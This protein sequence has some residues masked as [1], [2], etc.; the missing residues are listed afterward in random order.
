MMER[1]FGWIWV[2]LGLMGLMGVVGYGAYWHRFTVVVCVVMAW[3]CFHEARKG[4]T[5]KA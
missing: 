3:C 5:K 4:A 1:V 2:V